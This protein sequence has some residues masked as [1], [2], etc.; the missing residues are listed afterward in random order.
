[1]EPGTDDQPDVLAGHV[2][3]IVG[4]SDDGPRS[5]HNPPGGDRDGERNLLLLCPNHHTVV[6]KRPQTYTVERLVALKEEH[7]RWVREQ[8]AV[9]QDPAP[10]PFVTE[11]LHSSLLAVDRMPSSVYIAS[12]ELGEAEVRGHIRS[13]GK[14]HIALPYIVREKKLITLCALTATG[15]PFVDAFEPGTAERHDAEG[16]WHDPDL[17]RWYVTLLNRTLNK[18]TGRRGLNLDKEH[19]RYYFE[20]KRAGDGQAVAREVTY[21]PL[22]QKRS[23]K[24]VVWRPT[25]R[26]TGEPKNYWIHRAVRLRFHRVTATQWVLAIRPER[27]FTRDGFTALAPKT[28]GRRSTSLKSHM[29]NH[30]LLAELQF[31]KEFLSR[32]KPRIILDFGGQTLVVNAQFITGATEWPGVPGDAKPFENVAR[33]DDLFSSAAYRRALEASPG[34]DGELDWGELEDLIGLEAVQDADGEDS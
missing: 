15:N 25:R 22:N 11:V 9:D 1:M 18:L 2:A 31:W 17:S 13:P 30:D 21:R 16:W 26:K 28:I 24:S 3:H 12:T 20:P 34:D 14:P 23:S 10:T 27:R 29:Y 19:G 7:E 6:D 8:L 33:E 32:G 4:Q 5:E